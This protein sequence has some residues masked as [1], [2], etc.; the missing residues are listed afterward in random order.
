MKPIPFIEVFRTSVT[1]ER[2][3]GV[4]KVLLQQAFPSCRINFDLQD[5]DRILRMEGLLTVPV[6]M[7]L[8]RNQGYKCEVLE[9]VPPVASR[10]AASS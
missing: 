8:L 2:H 7:E 3:A 4:L 9:D 6:V 10:P 1:D 5:C